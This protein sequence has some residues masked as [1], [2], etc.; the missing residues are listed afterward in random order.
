[1]CVVAKSK[2]KE[3]EKQKPVAVPGNNI[4]KRIVEYFSS[5]PTP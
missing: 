2:E 4:F 5:R 1:M 3:K